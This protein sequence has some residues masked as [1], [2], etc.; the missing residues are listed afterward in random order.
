MINR[1]LRPFLLLK[2]SRKISFMAAIFRR[3]F[4]DMVHHYMDKKLRLSFSQMVGRKNKTS[5]GMS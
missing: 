1:R 2:K 3:F 5:F 4:A